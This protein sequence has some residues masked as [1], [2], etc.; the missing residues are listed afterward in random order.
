MEV[1]KRYIE[2]EDDPRSH[3]LDHLNQVLNNLERVV[4]NRRKIIKEETTNLRCTTT[5]GKK[6]ASVSLNQN[7]HLRETSQS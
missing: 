4:N 2:I 1:I 6:Y 5:D 7:S 3:Y